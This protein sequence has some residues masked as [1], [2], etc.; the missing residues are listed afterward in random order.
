MNPIKK[1]SNSFGKLPIFQKIAITYGGL[2]AISLTIIFAIVSASSSILIY[3]I[4]KHDLEDTASIV[5]NHLLNGNTLTTEYLNTLITDSHSTLAVLEFSPTDSSVNVI[6]AST[7]SYTNFDYEQLTENQ[8]F[9][10]FDIVTQNNHKVI[11][12]QTVLEYNNQKYILQISKALTNKKA[13]L[14]YIY[15]AF[16]AINFIGVSIAF[17][18]SVCISKKMLSPIKKIRN[19]AKRITIEDLS[20]RIDISGPNDD[21][22]DLA[23]T[24]NDMIDRLDTSFKKQNRFVSDASHELR[25]PIAV[26]QG[27][28][29]LIDRWGKSDP[30]ILQESI[31]SII[32]ETEHM[33]TL[34][35]KLLFLAK[36]D[37]NKMSVQKEK[38]DL[39]NI[40]S[41]IAK[42]VGVTEIK[43]KFKFLAPFTVTQITILADYNLI[44]QLIWVLLENS[45]KYTDAGKNITLS[46]YCDNTLAYI[47]VKDN[48]CGIPEEDIPFIFDRF[49]RVDKSRN[50]NIPGTGLGLSIAQLIAKRHDA[51]INVFSKVN[52]G[53]NVVI[54]FPLIKD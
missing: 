43:Q 5:K 36:N 15:L 38:V 3:T 8:E 12:Y 9:P 44:K 35:K 17:A 33:S 23:I 2:F 21:L 42:E 19:T 37:Q 25:T 18:L 40:C 4:I 20:K 10:D 27:Y 32:S 6:S 28:A 13:H 45:I 54:S 7:L 52:E 11:Y 46:V 22:K 50:K 24:F 39:K 26:I 51:K 30:A 34:V 48:G 49:Y 47:S 16:L 53:T 41:E 14:K 31:D 1:I 29:N